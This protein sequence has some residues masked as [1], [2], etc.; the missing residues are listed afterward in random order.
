MK[1]ARK[2]MPNE[3]LYELGFVNVASKFIEAIFKTL[4]DAVKAE[5]PSTVVDSTVDIK[6]NR[7][8]THE[9]YVSK[10][11]S[12][13]LKL[14]SSEKKEVLQKE[15]YIVDL[16]KEVS[17]KKVLELRAKHTKLRE[18]STTA[19]IDVSAEFEAMV[20][21]ELIKVLPKIAEKVAMKAEKI[22]GYP[23][24]NVEQVRQ[25]LLDSIKSQR[26]KK[27]N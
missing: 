20:K 18:G 1:N 14:I 21:E 7:V 10:D 11:E 12:V 6:G 3:T 24:A 22:H 13:T 2:I 16:E 15:A 17:K 19:D 8:N 26:Q 9:P 27:A 23:V 5:Y 4:K 25:T